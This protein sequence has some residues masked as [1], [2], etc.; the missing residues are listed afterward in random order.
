[1]FHHSVPVTK[2]LLRNMGCQELRGE[3]KQIYFRHQHFANFDLIGQQTPSHTNLVRDPVE[4]YISIYYY[5][6]HDHQGSTLGLLSRWK[7]SGYY[8]SPEW[9]NV[10]KNM[11][12]DTCV[13]N[14][15]DECKDS[16]F[17]FKLIPFFCGMDDFCLQP[18][19]KALNQAK[20]NIERY[21]PVVG[22]IENYEEYLELLEIVFP[23]FM[24]GASA[25]YRKT[26]ELVKQQKSNKD[27][28]Y[29]SSRARK[30]EEPSLKTKRIMK[31]RLKLEYQL[32][33]WIKQ[34]FQYMYAKY[35]GEKK[36][37][38]NVTKIGLS[39]GKD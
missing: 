3:E 10:R 15:Y 26:L 35:V 5:V 21:F 30:L 34:R 31:S 16:Y 33:E 37:I 8:K 14:N 20:Y 4:Q 13:Q 24:S 39:S 17:T 29:P 6:R 23:Q 7:N 27:P 1:M 36:N 12:F 9:L 25:S 28:G 38:G 2:Q 19:I 11:S 18:T 22:Y 32:Y